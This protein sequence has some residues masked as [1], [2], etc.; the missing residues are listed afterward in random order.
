MDIT[1]LCPGC[2]KCAA[3]QQ[4]LTTTLN[5]EHL[6]TEV[7]LVSDYDEIAAR[8][9][10]SVP[11][12]MIDGEIATAGTVPDVDELI[13]LLHERAARSDRP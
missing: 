1:I 8:G 13:G 10:R 5:H 11:T 3:L 9:V 12:L 7:V 4:N 6:D 2:P